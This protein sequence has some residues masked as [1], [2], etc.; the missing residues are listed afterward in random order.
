MLESALE[1]NITTIRAEQEAH[2][3]QNPED[4]VDKVADGDLSSIDLCS[5]GSAVVLNA[6]TG[7][8]L[9]SASYPSYDVNLFTNGI[10]AENYNALL[11]QEGNPLFN[12]AIASRMAPG[13]VFK[14]AIALAG[15]EEGV[16]TMDEIINDEGYLHRG[17]R[18][19]QY[20]RRAALL[21]VPNISRHQDQNVVDA[22][23]KFLQL[24]LL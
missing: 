21:G 2:L 22:H 20:R 10:S 15:L 12:K 1:E 3:A 4:Y 13:S 24:L 11:E 18:K 8:V 23:Q 5:E 9:A 6:K 19:R 17:D 7:E 16:I 14:V